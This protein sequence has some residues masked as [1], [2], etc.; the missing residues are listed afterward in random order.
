MGGF[1][2]GNEAAARRRRRLGRHAEP[3]RV[4]V[5]GGPAR[6]GSPTRRDSRSH[7]ARPGRLAASPGRSPTNRGTT[8]LIALSVVAAAAASCCSAAR[9]ASRRRRGR[10][11]SLPSASR[12]RSSRRTRRRRTPQRSCAALQR[13]PPRPLVRRRLVRTARARL[14]A[15]G[16]RDRRPRVLPEVGG[17]ARRARSRSTPHDPVAHSGLASL[18]LSRHRFAH[19]LALARQ[20]RTLSPST[21][22]QLRRRSATRSSSSAATARRSRRST[23]WRGSSRASPPTRASPMHASC[24]ATLAG[25]R[26]AMVLASETRPSPGPSRHAWTA[27]AARQASLL[28]RR[29]R[30]GR[31]GVPRRPW[32]TFPGYVY[33]LDALA[34]VEVRAGRS[35]PRDPRSSGAPSTT[36]PLPQYVGAL[37][38]L[39]RRPGTAR[40]RDAPVRARGAI[41]RLLAGER[42]PYRSRERPVRGR[43]RHRPPRTRS[44]RARIG[45]ARRPSIDGD[46]VLA[47]ALMP[48]RPLRGG[49]ALLEARAPPRHEGRAKLFHRGDDRALPRPRRRGSSLVR[50]R[51]LG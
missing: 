26:A 4:P 22:A 11:R 10:P 45:A 19:A 16:A 15:A 38:D 23:R 33:A 43:P 51:P 5:R 14:P 44:Q 20:A 2:K 17:G 48:E 34:Q 36:V 13:A 40:R 42:R 28:G 7:R 18:A 8:L 1:L 3:G 9:F 6:A 25:A 35:R 39:L 30:S 47:W 49:A 32:G 31:A 12:R 27:D 50:S 41:D 46:D 21:G 37:G 24:S 29:L